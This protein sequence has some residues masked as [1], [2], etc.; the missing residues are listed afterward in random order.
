MIL[1]IV[2]TFSP[3]LFIVLKDTKLPGVLDKILYAIIIQILNNSSL[4]SHHLR[5]QSQQ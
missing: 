2:I 1:L 4:I 5:K 3:P